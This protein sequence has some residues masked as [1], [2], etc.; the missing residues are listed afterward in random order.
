MKSHV[1]KHNS[2]RCLINVTSDTQAI[3]AFLGQMTT[4]GKPK[5]SKTTLLSYKKEY[6]RL[7][8]FCS[9]LK[10]KLSSMSLE[11]AQLFINMLMNPPETMIG[12]A[13]RPYGDKDWKPFVVNKQWQP[14]KPVLSPASVHQSVATINSLFSWLQQVGYVAL[15]PFSILNTNS[16]EKKIIELSRKKRVFHLDD[17]THVLNHIKQAQIQHQ[18]NPKVLR[19]INRQRWLF[20]AYLY[21]GLRI[22]ELLIN[23]TRS[24]QMTTVKGQKLW[25]LYVIG[26]GG[27]PSEIP[28]S[29]GFMDELY[30]YRFS[31]GLPQEVYPSHPE[32][33]FFNVTGSRAVKTRQQLYKVFKELI[34]EVAESLLLQNKRQEA[35][36][37]QSSSVHWLRHSFVTIALD[38]TDDINAVM[39]LARH[40]DL[41][42]TIGYDQSRMTHLS[43]VLDKVHKR[44][45]V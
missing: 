27:K 25:V 21:S 19:K 40:G 37:I 38:E 32:P 26:K 24:L 31:L 23:D 44:L 22:S 28:V 7:S 5:F 14:G 39:E 29:H 17:I 35:W 10:I 30:R 6:R 9:Q 45:K 1:Q 20:Y 16:S 12:N 3:N 43:H 8:W 42:T 36:R 34:Q 18:K 2:Y 11:D 13:K 33:F 15:N 41:K 4:T